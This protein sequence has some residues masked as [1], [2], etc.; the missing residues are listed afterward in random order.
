MGSFY[1]TKIPRIVRNYYSGYLWRYNTAE[2][3]VYLTFDDGPT[4]D[5]TDWVL[6]VLSLYGAAATFFLIGKN[7]E[8]HPKLAHRIID[9]GHVIG[10][11][12]YSHANGWK[13]KTKSYVR[14]VLRGKQII[15][16]Y[17]GVQTQLFRPPYGRIS[18][19]QAG[20]IRRNDQI[21]MM[22]VL[23]GDFDTE[24]TGES[25]FRNVTRHTKPGS[26]IVFHDSK[27]AQSRLEYSLPKTL[28]FLKENGYRF[29]SLPV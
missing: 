26:I 19:R 16:E 23:S 29:K 27:K 18:Q 17:T 21:V 2:K 25:C 14:D 3:V 8:K 10:N 28:E 11:H 6:D 13:V 20:L 1:F 4:P 7:V 5:V 9:A 12:S 15:Q 24:L 22:D